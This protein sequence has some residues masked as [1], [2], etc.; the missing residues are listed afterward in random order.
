MIKIQYMDISIL[1]LKKMQWI[2]D[3]PI[4]PLPQN[5]YLAFEG[6]VKST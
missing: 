4:W 3:G 5:K 2:F 6:Q 1:N